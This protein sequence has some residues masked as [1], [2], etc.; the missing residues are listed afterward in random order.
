[1]FH[2]DQ[3]R[4]HCANQ[5]S[6]STLVE[7]D[8]R[9]V[10]ML[11]HDNVESFLEAVEES[12]AV[13]VIVDCEYVSL[14]EVLVGRGFSLA[15]IALSDPGNSEVSLFRWGKADATDEFLPPIPRRGLPCGQYTLD[16][17]RL[18]DRP[19]LVDADNDASTRLHALFPPMNDTDARDLIVSAYLGWRRGPSST[20]IVRSTGTDEPVGKLMV[21]QL[22]PPGV[23]DVGYTTFPAHRGRG[24]ATTGLRGL[25]DWL[26]RWSTVRRIELGIKPANGSSIRTAEG[27][28]YRF[29]SRRTRRL[30][31]MDGTYDDEINY[32]AVKGNRE[33][34]R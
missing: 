31:N 29:E 12:A 3:T 4:S 23:V 19:L 6:G 28:G 13:H 5:V 20:L 1:M 11:D 14:L 33:G 22:V 26:F 27:A 15:P 16:Y 24:V 18:A 7:S 9:T 8:I 34:P 32:V 17:P 30:R 2:I 25:T 21:R 10:R